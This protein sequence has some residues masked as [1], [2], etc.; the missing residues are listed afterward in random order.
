MLIPTGERI[1][2]ERHQPGART[3]EQKE[4]K[5]MFSQKDLKQ[6]LDAKVCKFL[7]LCF[8]HISVTWRIFG[9]KIIVNLSIFGKIPAK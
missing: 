6:T 4:V 2:H 7:L 1:N 3:F 9:V 5:P 8:I